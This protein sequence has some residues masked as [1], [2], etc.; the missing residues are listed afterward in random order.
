MAVSTPAAG[1]GISAS[2]LSVEISNNGSSR[3]TVSPTFLIQRTTVPS[4]TDSPIWG[5]TTFVG[6]QI[7]YGL[8]ATGYLSAVHRSGHVRPQVACSL[9][10]RRSLGEGG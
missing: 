6:I 8:R 4:A 9:P 5:I 10:A 7:D 2:T 3:S 1:D